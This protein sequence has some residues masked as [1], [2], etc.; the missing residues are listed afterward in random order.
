MASGGYWVA[1]AADEIYV[2]RN[3]IV[4][5]IGVISAGF[6]FPEL[7]QKIGVERRV[8]AEGDQ[9]MRLDPFRPE[10]PEDVTWLKGIQKEIH[11]SFRALVK[12]RRG[13]KLMKR[14]D[15]EL[16]SG[17]VW[18]GSRAHELGLVDG[19][20]DLRGL[21]RERY[22]EKVRLRVIG[23]PRGWLRRK[24][25]LGMG[26]GAPTGVSPGDWAESIAAALAARSL[27]A[28]YGL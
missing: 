1:L 21:M 10:I 28:R 16:F 3:S 27:W 22:G 8:H 23:Q 24:L 9:K 12:E 25:G 11:G 6:G 20:A 13:D 18:V 4:G 17:E 15:K 2:N 19:V 26:S 7:L 5:S 14:K